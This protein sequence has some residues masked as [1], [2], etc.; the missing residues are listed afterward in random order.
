MIYTRQ[1]FIN[2]LLLL[3]CMYKWVLLKFKDNLLDVSRVDALE[4]L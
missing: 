4:N 1:L 2:A 3:K